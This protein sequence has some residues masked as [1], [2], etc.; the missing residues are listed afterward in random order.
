MP[1]DA[2]FFGFCAFANSC[3][4]MRATRRSLGALKP[5]LARAFTH[6]AVHPFPA[7]SEGIRVSKPFP[8]TQPS[9]IF[10][11]GAAFVALPVRQSGHG[12][13]LGIS[14]CQKRSLV[15]RLGR[16][17]CATHSLG[18]EELCQQVW[19]CPLA[20]ANVNP[21]ATGG[22]LQEGFVDPSSSLVKLQWESRMLSAIE[23]FA[24]RSK[25]I[26]QVSFASASAS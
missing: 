13:R 3:A 7:T 17:G 11:E 10:L 14:G 18:F 23:D 4:T 16:A 20:V 6:D 15:R 8:L 26:D 5:S 12:A 9:I 22:G 21:T 25:S 1:G 19:H 24:R 2:A